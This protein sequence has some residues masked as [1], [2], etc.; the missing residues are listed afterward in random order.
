MIPTTNIILSGS[1]QNPDTPSIRSKKPIDISLTQF[2]VSASQANVKMNTITGI[3]TVHPTVTGSSDIAELYFTPM[4][5]E[6][7]NYNEWKTTVNKSFSELE[8][9]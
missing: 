8:A 2:D 6:K 7:I 4:Y 1:V 3:I 5:K 9:R